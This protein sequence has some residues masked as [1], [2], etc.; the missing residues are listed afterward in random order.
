MVKELQNNISVFCYCS[1]PRLPRQGPWSQSIYSMN[2]KIHSGIR[3]C[4]L[5][6]EWVTGPGAHLQL[7]K[8]LAS[9]LNAACLLPALILA[10][11]V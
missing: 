10:G 1:L 2:K 5:G 4:N 3:N 7:A 6:T 11:K 9:V 8:Y